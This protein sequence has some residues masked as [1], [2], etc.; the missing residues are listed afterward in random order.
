MF[1]PS[2]LGPLCRRQKDD[3]SA[4]MISPHSNAPPLV[5]EAYCK[6]KVPL[7]VNVWIV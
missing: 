2:C 3:S 4:Q 1:G 7:L 6:T 5:A